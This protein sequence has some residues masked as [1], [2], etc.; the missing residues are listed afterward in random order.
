[1]ADRIVASSPRARAR[2]AGALYLI[3]AVPAGFSVSVFLKLVVRGDPAATAT[4]ILGWEGLFRFGL[5]AEIVGI[6]FF[7]GSVLLLYELFKP[8]SRSLARLFVSFSLIGAVIQAF[9]SIADVAAL[10]LLKGGGGLTA[11]TTGQAQALAFVLL[12]LHMLVY[13]LALVFFGVAFIL[14]GTL[15]LRSTFLPRV[16]GLLAAIDGLGYLTFSLTTFLSP[17]FAAHLYP[18]LPF[19]T[20]LLGEPPLMLWLVV[21]GVNAE[22]WEGQAAAG[23]AL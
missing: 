23:A 3:S 18:Y 20:A 16:L 22:R 8:V 1:V 12:R 9:D 6:L 13:D 5:V 10:I 11:F 2:L 21:K 15:I 17:P 4:H 7:V 19:L 14:L